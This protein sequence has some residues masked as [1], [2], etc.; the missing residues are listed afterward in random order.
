[1]PPGNPLQHRVDSRPGVGSDG[2]HAGLT[3]GGRPHEPVSTSSVR[4]RTAADIPDGP[5]PAD[6]ATPIAG[7]TAIYLHVP[8]CFHKCHYCDFYSIVDTRD[9]QDV[10]TDRLIEEVRSIGPRLAG[11]ITSVFV[12]GGTPTLLTCAQWERLG[13]SLRDSVPGFTAAEFTV[14]SNPETVT[15]ACAE[16]LARVGVN[17]VSIGAQSFDM[18]HLKTLERHHDPANVA[19]AAERFR[20]VGITDIN[21]DLIFGIPGQSVDDWKRDLEHVFAINPTHLS[22]YGLMYEANTPLTA[23]RDRGVLTP[24]DPDN[25]ACMYEAAMEAAASRGFEHYEI[26]NW[27]MPGRSCRHNLAYWKS[28]G[29]WPCGPSASGYAGGVRWKNDPHLG[30]YLERNAG[31]QGLPPI[32]DVDVVDPRTASGERF[33]LGLRLRAGL[34]MDAVNE[35]LACDVP[36]T[37]DRASV[38]TDARERGLLEVVDNRLRLTPRGLLLADSVLSELI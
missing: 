31:D 30:R 20:A 15:E 37:D 21:I 5:W 8:F 25:E 19:R 38:I 13:A 34:S 36:G 10:F 23:K 33:M 3:V 32:V 18:N 35:L 9:R 22:A 24:V 28:D 27:S 6:A 4:R 2:H 16:V 17:R 29:W 11:P 12:G 7:I 1:M 14:E 26:S